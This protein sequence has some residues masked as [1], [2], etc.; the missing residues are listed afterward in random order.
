MMVI[1][2]D[3]VANIIGLANEYNVVRGN[4]DLTRMDAMMKRVKAY[5]RLTGYMRG[6]TY[7][8]ILVVEA[9]MLYGRDIDAYGIDGAD[10]LDYWWKYVQDEWGGD[11]G[12]AD[13]AITYIAGKACLSNYLATAM[14]AL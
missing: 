12:N 8:E 13:D 6:L 7:D 1:Q 14:N 10:S 3:K 5:K 4:N 2:N 11:K 9:L